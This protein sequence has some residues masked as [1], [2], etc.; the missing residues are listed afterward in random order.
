MSELAL[1]PLLRALDLG[2]PMSS[3]SL[4]RGAPWQVADVAAALRAVE[5]ELVAFA[6]ADRLA[7]APEGSLVLVGIDPVGAI[8]LNQRRNA[9][10]ARSLRLVLW[11]PAPFDLRATAPDLDSWTRVRVDL[12]LALPEWALRAV[13]S[14]EGGRIWWM[15][16]DLTGVAAAV[17]PGRRLVEI[18]P[19]K[20]MVDRPEVL[21]DPAV[22][23][24]F[25]GVDGA[26]TLRRCRWA[27]AREGR[28]GPAVVCGPISAAPGFAPAHLNPLS[29]TE[30]ARRL[31][32]VEGG[33][34][35]AALLGLEP[36][37]IAARASEPVASRPLP[38]A[39]W[40]D[41]EARSLRAPP[42]D[43]PLRL[44]AQSPSPL[45]QTRIEA[46]TTA[47]L[48]WPA[49]RPA[50]LWTDLCVYWQAQGES[51][52]VAPPTVFASGSV[53]EQG[54]DGR[55]L[56]LNGGGD[57]ASEGVGADGDGSLTAHEPSRR[58]PGAGAPGGEIKDLEAVREAW[59]RALAGRAVAEAEAMGRR[60]RGL[61]FDQGNWGQE[62]ELAERHL[63]A[64]PEEV[65]AWLW[66]GETADRL[67]EVELAGKRLKR[68]L[69]L[70]EACRTEAKIGEVL[71][72]L[73]VVQRAQ[74]D[75]SGA[76]SSLE[77]SLAIQ[78]KVLGTEEHPFVA[79]SLHALAGVLESQG[80][81][82]GARSSLERSLAILRK[83]LGTKD[84]PDVAASLHELG[85]ILR[86]QGDLPAARDHLE[87]SLAI[88]RKVL[89]TEEHPSVAA[90]LHALAGVLQAQGDL[91]A[92]RDHLERSLV[93]QRKVLNTE[94]HPSVAATLHELAGVLQ[95]Q[96]DLAGARDHLDRSLAI[97]RKV[98]G[99]GVHLSVAA[100]LHE[101]A[102]VLRAQG[103]L[104]A[105][106]DHLDRSLAIQ[107]KVLGTEEHPDVAAS[108]H[109]L[110][111]VLQAQGDLPA[112]EQLFERVLQINHRAFG[113]MDHYN[114]AI[115]EVNLADVVLARGDWER[116]TRL[117]RHALGVFFAQ[118]GPSHQFTQVAATRLSNLLA[119]G[120]GTTSGD[121]TAL[122]PAARQAVPFVL[123]ALAAAGGP[124]SAVLLRALSVRIHLFR[125]LGKNYHIV[126]VADF[127][128][129][130]PGD[131]TRALRVP[132]PP[133]EAPAA[134]VELWEADL[135]SPVHEFLHVFAPHL[136]AALQALR[137]EANGEVPAALF[138]QVDADE[139]DQRALVA[140]AQ[141]ALL[142]VTKGLDNLSELDRHREVWSRAAGFAM[143]LDPSAQ[144]AS[145]A[146]AL[147][148]TLPA[149]ADALRAAWRPNSAQ[150]AFLNG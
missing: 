3:V 70:A 32:A 138:H 107:R 4:V 146:Q 18:D 106:R 13:R 14:A 1:R 87:R 45:E 10:S 62:R 88:Q 121:T 36:E 142:R 49:L 6:E 7:A 116:A 19:V 119:R 75:L 67:G 31:S 50:L 122:N 41:W 134:L 139:D 16:G 85:R 65:F 26:L 8:W 130:R 22:I 20:V 34:L 98:L 64:F 42:E 112:A 86:A 127:A 55:G 83:V 124:L 44:E 118:F 63:A 102:S 108:L 110:A 52:G 145:L 23:P 113:G 136:D 33:A 131:L 92:A 147:L 91:A 38:G 74:G 43:W 117:L 94:E 123:H 66:A 47:A 81:L 12:P 126:E 37:A 148:A 28:E 59:E 76:R 5:P 109:A 132:P 58:S 114:S 93:I 128:S 77:R 135:A 69:E 120:R 90:S 24:V 60:L 137:R 79:A 97:D 144:G 27:L 100:T 53:V 99:T 11:M 25:V 40:R 54:M 84:H 61:L 80:D 35:Q 72:A 17:W 30:A 57:G 133:P 101:L 143:A 51:M 78:H 125:S 129:E 29:W 73:G 95:A 149:R 82:S 115:A 89:G 71:H 105:A 141:V 9:I 96:G 140:E 48:R 104:P 21:A 111:G 2:G 15:G 103:D 150:Q 68:A 46:L 39:D 56:G